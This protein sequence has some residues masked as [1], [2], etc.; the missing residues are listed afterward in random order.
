MTANLRDS[1]RA[2]KPRVAEVTAQLC[3][4]T[5][6]THELTNAGY[7]TRC[8]HCLV[9]WPTLDAA[10]NVDAVTRGEPS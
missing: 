10:L 3:P 8:R 6:G 1:S 2:Y 7:V 5:T 4:A 9:D